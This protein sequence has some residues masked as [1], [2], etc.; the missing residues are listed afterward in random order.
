MTRGDGNA[1]GVL[2]VTGAY[3][4]ELSGGGL[5]CKAIV[6]A[7]RNELRCYVLTTS[8]DPKLPAHDRV[9]GTPVRRVLI[10]VS[11]PLSKARA[12]AAFTLTL[13][14]LRRRI[15]IVH[16]HGFSQK[17]SLVVALARLFGKQVV[18]T[19]HTAEQDEPDAVRRQGRLAS[20]AYARIDLFIAVSP[21]MA[22]RMVGAG[23][24]PSRVWQGSNGLDLE[25]FR[26]AVEGE[27]ASLR[28]ELGLASGHRLILFVGF[29]SHDKGPE[30]LFEAW[31]RIAHAQA[32][33]T[34]LVFVG[35]TRS[36]YFEVDPGIA[37][38]IRE[39]AARE[40]LA[41]RVVFVETT[42][43]IEKF[44]RA[45]DLFVFPSRREAFG[46]ALVEAMAS[47]LPCI[48]SR[49]PG[50]TDAIVADGVDGLLV[51]PHDVDALSDRMARL[52]ADESLSAALG[53]AA[54]ASVAARFAIQRTARGVADAYR[55]VLG[56]D[57][58]AA[59]PA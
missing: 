46:M 9:D 57:E 19:L 33:S 32:A 13:F 16:L 1:I 15:R 43:V 51:A 42:R 17:A 20:W 21:G 4:P 18:M 14:R 5:Q 25:R 39:K 28:R 31:R 29:F 35:A 26:P 34:M 12:A 22:A 3:D 23:V 2:M 30:I 52:L 48:S 50:V 55:H 44:Y 37:D 8:T 6:D 36:P 10:D 45:A 58:A 47:G 56:A 24:D 7:L 40:G 27:R 41:G 38:R 59:T 11:S 53:A 49:L 54:R